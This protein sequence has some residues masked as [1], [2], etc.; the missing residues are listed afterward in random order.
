MNTGLPRSDLVVIAV[1]ALGIGALYAQYWQAPQPAEHVLVRA[2]SAEAARYP[3]NVA[4]TLEIHGA[5]G[6]S[7]LRVEDGR[8]RFLDGPCRNRVC[9]HSGWLAHRGDAA[10]CLPNR[11]SI[12]L[13]GAGAPELDAVSF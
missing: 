9:V 11:V 3:L 10:A 12:S 4:R 6:I 8:V 5:R 2:G 1:A 13:G 7:I